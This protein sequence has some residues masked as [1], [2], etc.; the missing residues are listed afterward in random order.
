MQAT[1]AIEVKRHP[2]RL[3]NNE[4]RVITR[5]FAFADPSRLERVLESVQAMS[6]ATVDD[7]LRHVL[8][9]FESRHE[10]LSDVLEENFEQVCRLCGWKCE[11][12]PNRR[13]LLGS[14]FTMEYSLESVALFNPSIIPHPDFPKDGN[15]SLRFL[16]SMRATGEGHVSSVV[17]R[18]GVIH[19][20]GHVNVDAPHPFSSAVK[21]APDQYYMKHLFRRKLS[22]L[23]GVA[24]A[25]AS[26]FEHLSDRFTFVD[27]QHAIASLRES[28]EQP[29]SLAEPIDHMLWLARSNYQLE[30]DK[31]ADLSELVIF[32]N[33]ESE[34]R[35]IEDLR[36][37]RFTDDDGSVT[38]YGS[39]TAYNGFRILPMLLDTRDF[40]TIHVHSLNGACARN[41]G[42]ALFP[43][44]IGG[45]F[46]MCS[47]LDG[48]NLYIMYSD[49]VHFWETA[50][51][52]AS[53]VQPWE[54]MLIGN[55]GSPIETEAGW[56]LIT[57]GVGPMRKYCLG[58]MLL[59]LDDPTKII[60]RLREPLISPL[61]EER[62]GY[63]PNVVYTCGSI[64]HH[65]RLY[66]PYAMADKSTSM[67]SVD[68]SELINLL[69]E[70]PP[71]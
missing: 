4:R 52:L 62:E 38:Y 18:T 23:G 16:M 51:L 25:V 64:V 53:P 27:L 46:A 15:D 36:M 26:I 14:Y 43:R 61:D 9:S 68:L 57:H 55:A 5:L 12:A 20:N 33:A 49:M 7:T 19:A 66:I 67:A 69:L 22:E 29:E 44:R 28:H 60:G 21:L 17:F 8:H 40:R 34:S 48:Q 1:Q 54:T 45:H 31:N 71:T 11:L 32:P 63:V 30:L 6:D 2:V 37:V 3:Q 42:L 13:L 70:N 39:Y 47:R 58:A 50:T 65:G 41:K 59:D 35:G 24:N 10:D 56:L